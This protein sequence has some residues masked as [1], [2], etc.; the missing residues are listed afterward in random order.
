MLKAYGA[1]AA[2]SFFWGTTYL[3]IRIGVET[4]PPALFAGLRFL[5][6]GCFFLPFLIWRGY[7]LPGRRDILHLSV[8]GIA[9]LGIANGLVVWAEQIVPSG[10]AALIV[11]TLPLWMV[12]ME[13]LLPNGERLTT[14]K[15]FGILVGF[16]GLVLLLWPDLQHSLELDS[17]Y[18]KGL[19]ALFFAPISWGAGSVYAKRHKLR[20][21][22]LMSAAS[23]ML[24]AGALLTILGGLTGEF[25]A[26]TFETKGMAAMIYLA[27]FG[28]IVGY[29]S[30]IYALEKLPS[31]IV[32]TYAYLNPVVA[33]ILGCL[34]LNERFDF[35]LVIATAI[36]LFGV[37]LVT[38]DRSIPPTRLARPAETPDLQ[39]P[40]K[41]LKPN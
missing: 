21:R 18:V 7:E 36:I 12:S 40:S 32:S 16:T 9:L 41:C 37:I 1:F 27:I 19:V 23:Q 10:L 34:V 3:A 13:S 5:L 24:V 38:T 6:A 14:R 4:V 20:I 33:V 17:F 22:P 35:L 15:V 25:Q 39:A 30:Y 2:V 29:G 31:S 8:T 26:F 11:A 28:S